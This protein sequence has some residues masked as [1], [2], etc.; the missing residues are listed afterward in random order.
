MHSW[1]KYAPPKP[2][3]PVATTRSRAQFEHATPPWPLPEKVESWI[4]LTMSA[5]LHQVEVWRMMS[6]TPALSAAITPDTAD[7]A[8]STNEALAAKSVAEWRRMRTRS[9]C[10]WPAIKARGWSAKRQSVRLMKLNGGARMS[11]ELKSSEATAAR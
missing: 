4:V 6:P 1:M 7:A 8:P 11:P 9:S 10:A 5:R 3:L 2:L